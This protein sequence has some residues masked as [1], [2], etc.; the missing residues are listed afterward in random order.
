MMEML[1]LMVS[2]DVL[3]VVCLMFETMV[4]VLYH[5]VFPGEL[6]RFLLVFYLS[7]A[8]RHLKH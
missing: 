5:A 7:Q 2:K 6:K 8:W 3:M 1:L 4:L